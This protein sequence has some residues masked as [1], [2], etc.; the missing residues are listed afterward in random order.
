MLTWEILG[1]V[2][3]VA[4]GALIVGRR[5]RANVFSVLL[6]VGIAALAVAVTVVRVHQYRDQ[7]AASGGVSQPGVEA[8]EA[9]APPAAPTPSGWQTMSPMVKPPTGAAAPP[10]ARHPELNR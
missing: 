6:V 5:L 1:I 3:V 10:A 7:E 2:F 8:P 4:F 9:A